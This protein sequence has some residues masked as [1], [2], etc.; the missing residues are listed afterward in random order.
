M[1]DRREKNRSDSMKIFTGCFVAFIIM[2]AFAVIYELM[3]VYL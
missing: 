2:I 1:D 3:E